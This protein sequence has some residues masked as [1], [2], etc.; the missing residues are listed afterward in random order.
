MYYGTNIFC[1]SLIRK[2]DQDSANRWAAAVGDADVLSMKQLRFHGHVQE[3]SFGGPLGRPRTMWI[4]VQRSAHGTVDVAEPMD[5]GSKVYF[6]RQLMGPGPSLR[7]RAYTQNLCRGRRPL[8][9]TNAL[10]A[11]IRTF[12]DS[13]E[14]R[15][16]ARCVARLSAFFE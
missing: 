7:L 6:R 5:D 2:K 16:K 3:S 10:K 13:C 14:F 8:S 12:A 9:S 4:A 1:I 11:L 15:K